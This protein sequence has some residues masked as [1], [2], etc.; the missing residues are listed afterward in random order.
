V[1]GLV[2]SLDGRRVVRVEASGPPA[3]ARMIGLKL[4]A[5]ARTRG[6]GALIP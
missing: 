4:A 2:A 1:R 6:A 3:G 5:D